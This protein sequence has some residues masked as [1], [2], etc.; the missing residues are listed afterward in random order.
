MLGAATIKAEE[1]ILLGRSDIVLIGKK[2][3]YIIEMKVD[4]SSENALKQIKEMRYYDI[5]VNT[6][7]TIH[8]IGMSFDSKK[9]EIET[10]IEEI[11]DK[12]KE[13]NWIV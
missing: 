12:A 8:L 11:V 10:Y 2:D 5:Y 9:R 3:V 7:K 4:D 13:S 6:N 1:T